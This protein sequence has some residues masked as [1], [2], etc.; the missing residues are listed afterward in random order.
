MHVFEN[1]RFV[2]RVIQVFGIILGLASIGFWQDDPLLGAA[3]VFVGIATW[4]LGSRF[5]QWSTAN[6]PSIEQLVS[7]PSDNSI[8]SELMHKTGCTKS[9]LRPMGLVEIGGSTVEACSKEGFLPKGRRVQVV[10]QR[11]GTLIVSEIRDEDHH[12]DSPGTARLS[13]R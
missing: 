1:L 4:Y 13:D 10:D 3:I 8:H 9:P 12:A 2:A 5:H 7:G 6:D 11:A